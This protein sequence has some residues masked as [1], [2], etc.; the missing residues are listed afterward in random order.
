MSSAPQYAGPPAGSNRNVRRGSSGPARLATAWIAPA[1]AAL[2]LAPVL[3]VMASLAAGAGDLQQHIWNTTGP[4]YLAGTLMLCLVVGALAAISGAGAGAF[5]ALCEFPGRRVLSVALVLPFAVPAYIMAYAYADLLG[6]FGPVSALL[7]GPGAPATRFIPPIRTFGGAGFILALSSYAYVYL[8]VRASLEARSAAFFEAARSLGARPLAAGR[9]VLLPTARAA[10]AGGLA[11]ALMETV[12][13]FGVADYFGVPTLSVGIFRT[14]YGFGDLVAASQIAAGLFLIALLLTLAEQSSR[15]GLAAEGARAR[16]QSARLKL[17]GAAAFAAIM[18]C[19][20]PPLLG[21]VIP[22][23]TLASKLGQQAPAVA[24]NQFPAAAA[25]TFVLAAIVAAISL[26]L[27]GALAM[28]ARA[29][30]ARLSAR[31]ATMGYALPGAMLAIGVLGVAAALR[32]TTGLAIAGGALLVYA[33]TLRFLTAGYNALDG[34]L[35]Q[36]HPLTDDAARALGAHPL[37]LALGVHLPLAHR[38]AG[39]GL[40]IVFIDVVK[41]LPAT[42]LLRPFNFET[43][44]TQVYRLASDERFADAAPAA[45]ALIGVSLLPALWLNAFS[46]NGRR[47][48]AD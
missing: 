10:L 16:R 17:N 13:E 42:L 26:A 1:A 30:S 35:A 37:R 23:L 18:F 33:L 40:L 25:N 32:E 22:A 36:I 27:A 5:I 7:G 6:P 12:A 43:L 29:G 3:F 15:R 38:A 47:Q 14:W 24:H 8:A 39:A 41:E 45:L 34:G 9:L 31:V 28:K 4:R 20:L 19:A 2:L 48:P 44:A 11:L 46:R 21:F